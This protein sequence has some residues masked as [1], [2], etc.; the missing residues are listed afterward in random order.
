[1]RDDT[2]CQL[3]RKKFQF[4]RL[5]KVFAAID[6][7]PQ[8]SKPRWLHDLS[9]PSCEGF[10]VSWIPQ[11]CLKD[12]KLVAAQTGDQI[13]LAKATAEALRDYFQ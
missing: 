6:E 8:G 2:S 3:W 12:C 7:K 11:L 4:A 5:E 10:R 13:G 9:Q 1:M